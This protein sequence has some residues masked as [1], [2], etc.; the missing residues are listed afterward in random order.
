M[1]LIDYL[2]KL[3]RKEKSSIEPTKTTE[4]SI[5]DTSDI[6]IDRNLTKEEEKSRKKLFEEIN[7]E[8]FSTFSKTSTSSD[9]FDII[10]VLLSDN[11][12]VVS[13]VTFSSSNNTI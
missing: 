3:F 5:I 10:I 11:S 9:S 7:S 2:K 13:G 4:L 12:S 1:I 8:D 6:E